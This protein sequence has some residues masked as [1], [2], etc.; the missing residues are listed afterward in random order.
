MPPFAL[1][2]EQALGVDGPSRDGRRSG[3]APPPRHRRRHRRGRHRR[4]PCR[5]QARHRQV[6]VPGAARPHRRHPGGREQQ[7]SPLRSLRAARRGRPRR[8]HRGHRPR[9]HDAQG[10]TQRVRRSMGDAHEVAAAAAREVA[11]P[12][13][14][15]SAA[16]P[17]LP[18]PDRRRAAPSVLPR[19][20]RGVAHDAPRARRAWLHRV[21]GADAAD[22][23]R[24]CQRQAVHHPSPRARHPDEA[25]YLAR[26][27]PQAHAR[28]R[29]RARVRAGPQLPQRGHRPRPQPGVLDARGLPG[30]RRLPLDDGAQ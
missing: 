12:A 8:H 24:R 6:A 11:R 5:A 13:G 22:G 2:L 29:G 21:R 9:R 20:G 1:T 26:A 28:R 3:R 17:A 30:L 18:A 23:G 7:R 14:P 15:R 27:V 4:G 19:T 25:A 16:A 10:R